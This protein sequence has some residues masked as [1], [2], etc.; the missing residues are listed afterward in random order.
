MVSRVRDPRRFHNPVNVFILLWLEAA[1]KQLPGFWDHS[2]PTT[3]YC[4]YRSV[5]SGTRWYQIVLDKF[6]Y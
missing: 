2:L 3:Q 1:R 4:E 5:P 6:R